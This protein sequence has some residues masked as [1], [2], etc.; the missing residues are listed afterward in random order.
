MIKGDIFFNYKGY[1]FDIEVKSLQTNSIKRFDDGTMKAVFQC[2]ASDRRTVTLSDGTRFETTSLLVGEF[3][4]VAVCLFGFYG[5]WKFVFAKNSELP[6]V[7]GTRGRAKGLTEQQRNE[8]LATIM[9]MQHPVVA[10]YR[11][12]PWSILDDLIAEGKARPVSS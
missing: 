12:E 4:V 10:P 9:P 3:D 8:L 1:R 2:D 6:R 11:D 7:K 5:D